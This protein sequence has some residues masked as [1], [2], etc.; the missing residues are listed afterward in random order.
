[1]NRMTAKIILAAFI[2]CAFFLFKFLLFLP[3]Y[4]RLKKYL[5]TELVRSTDQ[6]ERKYWKR[7]LRKLRCCFFPFISVN[8]VDAIFNLFKRRK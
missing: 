3:N 7:E 4:I 1:M 5:K 8:N 2:L 6:E